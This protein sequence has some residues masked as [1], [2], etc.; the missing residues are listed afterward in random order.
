[1]ING[2]SGFS[3]SKAFASSTYSFAASSW[4]LPFSL[5]QASHLSFSSLGAED[6]GFLVSQSPFSA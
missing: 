5:F 2:L 4:G 6:L 1:L 3:P